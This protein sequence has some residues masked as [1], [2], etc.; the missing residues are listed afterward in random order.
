MLLII[1]LNV[2]ILNSQIKSQSGK[3]GALGQLRG[4][5]WGGRWEGGSEWGNTC[6]PV[7]DSCQYMA[8]NSTIL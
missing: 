6:T 1:T 5:G 3:A 8:K 4:M 7:T 2:N